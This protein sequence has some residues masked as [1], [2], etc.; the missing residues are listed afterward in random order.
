MQHMTFRSAHWVSRDN[1]VY[2]IADRE[3]MGVIL[4]EDS[5]GS[6]LV[7]DAID[8]FHLGKMIGMRTAFECCCDACQ[9]TLISAAQM[10]LFSSASAMAA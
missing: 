1:T 4:S 6:G 8:A 2:V 9:Q 10:D 7:I 3:G 5:I